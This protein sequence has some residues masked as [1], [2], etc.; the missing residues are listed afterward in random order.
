MLVTNAGNKSPELLTS[1]QPAA[2]LEIVKL[3]VADRRLAVIVVSLRTSVKSCVIQLRLHISRGQDRCAGC[4]HRERFQEKLLLLAKRHRRHPLAFAVNAAECI[5]GFVL[6][7][8]S[9]ISGRGKANSSVRM[10]RGGGG[11]RPKSRL[12][13][14]PWI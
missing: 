13:V 3:A 14:S 10:T 7:H 11:H 9:C 2:C 8:A 12:A 4:A 1:T 5:D 6:V